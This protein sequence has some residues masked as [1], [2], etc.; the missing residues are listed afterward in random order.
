MRASNW[1]END[2][3]LLIAAKYLKLD[4]SYLDEESEEEAAPS[5]QENAMP[6]PVLEVAFDKTLVAPFEVAPSVTNPQDKVGD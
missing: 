6:D 2:F 5:E 3:C 1:A 4:F